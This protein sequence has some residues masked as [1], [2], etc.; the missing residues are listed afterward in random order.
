M[1]VHPA[2]RG[3][4]RCGRAVRCARWPGRYGGRGSPVR[5]HPWTTWRP[6][7]FQV[8]KPVTRVGVNPSPGRLGG[9]QQLVAQ[10]A[11]VEPLR[12]LQHGPPRRVGHCR[13]DVAVIC[14]CRAVILAARAASDAC[15]CHGA[16]RLPCPHGSSPLCCGCP[17]LGARRARHLGPPD[18]AWTED[19]ELTRDVRLWAMINGTR[20]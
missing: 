2:Y 12:S 14:S 4:E 3:R 6:S 1:S 8:P 16:R 13:L 9:E 20:P 17:A 19:P 15:R 5:S 18:N 10:A 11:A 7:T